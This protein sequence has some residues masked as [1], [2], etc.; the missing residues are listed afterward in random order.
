MRCRFPLS[1]WVALA[2]LLWLLS[3]CAFMPSGPHLRYIGH[4]DIPHGLDLGG[5]GMPGV[6]YGGISGIDRDPRT[7]L[8]YLISDDRSQRGPARFLTARIDVDANGIHAVDLLS[9]IALRDGDGAVFPPPGGGR[10]AMDAETLR[11][12]PFTGDLFWT[13]E[14]DPAAGGDPQLTQSRTDGGFVRTLPLP[15]AWRFDTAG[16][17]G[18]RPNMT[19]EGLALARD[20]DLFLAMEAPLIQDGPIPTPEQGGWT[21]ISRLSRDGTLRRQYAYR[22]D[23][24]PAR[25]AGKFADNGISEIALLDDERLLILERAGIQAADGHFAFDVR[26]YLADL[27]SAGDVGQVVSLAGAPPARPVGKRLVFDFG[28]LEG[29][30]PDN[31]EAMALFADP[32]TGQCLLLLASD[33]NFHPGQ[34]SHF[35]LF[36]VDGVPRCGS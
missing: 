10:P 11:L 9:A 29:R 28:R 21:R 18:P 27:A 25:P 32:S 6:P 12:D 19:L 7:G 17:Q 16:G 2:A 20:G 30:A 13:S 3:G 23:P 4:Y 14:G 36:A 1:A 34:R 33:D 24:I 35:L 15:P 22:L 8:W 5:Q 31:L 26:L